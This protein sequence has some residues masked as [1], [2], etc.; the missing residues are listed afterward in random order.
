MALDKNIGIRDFLLFE[1]LKAFI[2]SGIWCGAAKILFPGGKT[3][4]K[5]FFL[6]D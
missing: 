4:N 1:V 6:Q 3:F 5:S 2:H